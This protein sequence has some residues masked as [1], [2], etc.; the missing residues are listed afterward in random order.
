MSL[1]FDI[2][3]KRRLSTP[4]NPEIGTLSQFQLMVLCQLWNLKISKLHKRFLNVYKYLPIIG[5]LRTYLDNHLLACCASQINLEPC[6]QSLWSM[7]SK[8]RKK[9]GFKFGQE[10]S[11]NIMQGLLG[12]PLFEMYC[13]HMGG[14]LRSL[15]LVSYFLYFWA[16][17]L[18]T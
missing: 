6:S 9:L 4:H 5:W 3:K 11:W 18:A 17:F 8:W 12:K 15:I 16:P 13:F 7:F 2:F 1:L 14:N 10:S